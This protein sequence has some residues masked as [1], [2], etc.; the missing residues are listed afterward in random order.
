M[1]TGS[2]TGLNEM[3]IWPA[4]RSAESVLA[5]ATLACGLPRRQHRYE[6]LDGQSVQDFGFTEEQKQY[7]E[8][9]IAALIKK[10]GS[11]LP[12]G[13]SFAQTNAQSHSS[14][15]DETRLRDPAYIHR[16]AQDRWIEAGAKLVPEEL[17]KRAKHP[18]DMWDEM[19][20]DEAA[21]R[22]HEGTDLFLQNF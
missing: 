21:G 12:T 11:D 9:F 16:E 20:R 6:A 15:A 18:F 3:T 13:S 8:G 7:L 19:R 5:A 17:A 1:V 22:L 14:E 4:R 10:R 2:S